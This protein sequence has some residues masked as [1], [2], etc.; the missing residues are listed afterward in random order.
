MRHPS[1]ACLKKT[2]LHRSMRPA[3][4]LQPFG[5]V[6]T[7]LFRPLIRPRR[8]ALA[9]SLITTTLGFDL[10]RSRA[11]YSA[12]AGLAYLESSRPAVPAHDRPVPHAPRAL[13]S[14]G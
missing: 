2:N 1:S 13:S 4:S 10:S 12:S 14:T 9:A 7:V 11:Y 8:P 6:T 5:C 3:H